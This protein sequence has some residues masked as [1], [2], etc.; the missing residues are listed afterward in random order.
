MTSTVTMALL[1]ALS[2]IVWPTT[3]LPLASKRTSGAA[4]MNDHRRISPFGYGESPFSPRA[5][6]WSRPDLTES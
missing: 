3:S 5:S 1:I 4:R 2:E 6:P